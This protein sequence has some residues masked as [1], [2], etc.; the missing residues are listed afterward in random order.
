MQPALA[1]DRIAA[2]AFFRAGPQALRRLRLRHA[3]APGP[4]P[5]RT[6]EQLLYDDA[7]AEIGDFR[8]PARDD[9]T[10]GLLGARASRTVSLGRATRR[11]PRC[12]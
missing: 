1:R 3:L 7:R 10:A 8:L 12:S 9:P 4:V 2:D 6:V 5:R 11:V